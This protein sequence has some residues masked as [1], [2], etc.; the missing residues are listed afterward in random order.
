MKEREFIKRG[1]LHLAIR[2]YIMEKYAHAKPTDVKVI[3]VPGGERIV[4]FCLMPGH[5]IG[6]KGSGI[7]RLTAELEKNF[8]IKDPQIDVQKVSNANLDPVAIARRI[9]EGLERGFSYRR[10]GKHYLK[11]V[12]DAGAVGCEIIIKGKVGGEKSRKARFYDGY[13]IKSGRYFETKV[14]K[15]EAEAK[16]KL[17]I[18]KIHVMIL[19][20]DPDKIVI[21]EVVENEGAEEKGP[22]K[23]EQAG[24]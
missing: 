13:V 4:I 5:I 3:K 21:P 20:E 16:L 18:V 2:E 19:L 12:M 14:Y 8:G 11:R 23:A 15:G 9:A 7:T 10:L 24:A 1:K 6:Q 22:E 17:G